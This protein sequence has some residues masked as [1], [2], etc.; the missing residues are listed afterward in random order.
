M[1]TLDQHE[2]SQ[3]SGA[4]AS[5]ILDAIEGGIWG[6]IDGAMTGMGIGG[7]FGGAGFW[8]F[9]ALA[10]LVGY[11]VTP[12]IAGIAGGLLGLTQGREQAAATIKHYRDS[13]GGG[14]GSSS[15]PR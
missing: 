8:G 7:K 12:F 6:V 2:V 4:W 15:Q 5:S 9:G 11:A 3:V 13:L 10:Q 14:N 1:R